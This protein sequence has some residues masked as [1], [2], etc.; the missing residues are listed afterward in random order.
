MTGRIFVLEDYD[1][2]EL[3]AELPTPNI[4]ENSLPLKSG[5]IYKDLN[6]RGYEYKGV[7][8]GVEEADNNGKN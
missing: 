4:D 7:F 2:E 3:N 6:L 1:L 8:R 5:D